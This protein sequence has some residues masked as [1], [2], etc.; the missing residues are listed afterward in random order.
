M[1]ELGVIAD[2]LT[3]A[4]DTGVQ[5]RKYGLRTQVLL[6]AKSDEWV[7]EADVVVVDTDSRAVGQAVAE[8]RVR[9]ACRMFAS[10]NIANLYKKIDSTLRGNIGAEISAACNEFKPAVTII[11]PAFPQTGR[12]T[13]GGY[14]LLNG[15]PISRTEISRDPKTPVKEAYLPKLL[16]VFAGNR[17]ATLPLQ[18]VMEGAMAVADAINNHVAAGRNWI[19]CDA[20]SEENLLHIAEAAKTFAKVLWVG[21]AGLAEQLVLAKDWNRVDKRQDQPIACK[22]ILVAAGSV[23]AVTQNQ[24]RQFLEAGPA[25]NIVL[26]AVAAVNSPQTEAHRLAADALPLMNQRIAVISCSNEQSV[27]AAVAAAGKAR[28]MNAEEVGERIASAMGLAVQELVARG[29]DGLFLTGGETAVSCC[30][31]LGAIGVEILREVAPGIPLGRILGGKFHGLP[32]VT[33]AGAFGDVHAISVSV[34]ALQGKQ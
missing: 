4:N 29:I 6:A 26:D 19:I 17:L 5:F 31:A 34:A 25:K 13:V 24:V 15:V 22:A 32:I 33:K 21:S 16:S 28:G 12:N 18:V 11:A 7:S 14:Q 1:P 2:D 23:S 9:E 20:A 27:L 3:G 8:T 30:R 10:L